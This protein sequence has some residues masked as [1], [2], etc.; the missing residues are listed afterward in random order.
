MM[1]IRCRSSA[2]SAA[3]KEKEDQAW[4]QRPYIT[5][6]LVAGAAILTSLA[7]YKFLK[8]RSI[9]FDPQHVAYA[10]HAASGTSKSRDYV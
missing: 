5:I 2:A 9:L 4:L 3:L 6:S 8:H 7:G 10:A 1:V